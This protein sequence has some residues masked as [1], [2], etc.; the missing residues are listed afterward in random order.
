MSLILGLAAAGVPVAGVPVGGLPALDDAACELVLAD[1]ALCAGWDGCAAAPPLP[2][3]NGRLP[4][5]PPD[6]SG[7][8]AGFAAAPSLEPPGDG[9]FVVPFGSAVLPFVEAAAGRP[10][11]AARLFGLLVLRVTTRRFLPDLSPSPA[12]ASVL[13][14]LGAGEPLA[15]FSART[16]LPA[17]VLGVSAGRE[18]AAAVP[19]A[20]ATDA[21]APGP[22]A[23]DRGAGRCDVV[24]LSLIDDVLALG[25][26]LRASD[27]ASSVA[28]AAVSGG[29]TAPLGFV[30]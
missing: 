18:L 8:R 13:D 2:F 9:S 14:L 20:D 1:D 3:G 24:A 29:V 4:P 27:A 22:A 26:G 17:D 25:T 30:L 19:L 11:A 28:G 21:P 15:S 6:G 10:R 16:L 7:F 23:E 5:S 12:L